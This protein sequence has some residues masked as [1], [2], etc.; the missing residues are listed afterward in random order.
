MKT[1]QFS[2]NSAACLHTNVIKGTQVSVLDCNIVISST[3]G[4]GPL[5][6]KG[7]YMYDIYCIYVMFGD[8]CA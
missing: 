1:T 7:E 6:L 3:F 2:L 8:N 4:S 5:Q